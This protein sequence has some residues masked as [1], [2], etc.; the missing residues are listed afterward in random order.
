MSEVISNNFEQAT[1]LIVDD[2][3]TNLEMVHSIVKEK[4]NYNILISNSSKNVVDSLDNFYCDL[5]LLDIIMPDIDGYELAKV[6]KKHAKFKNIPILFLTSLTEPHEIIKG[7]KVGGVDY[8]TKPFIEEELLARI[9]THLEL[10]FARD[11]LE[12]RELQLENLVEKKSRQIHNMTLSLVVALEN[13]NLYNDE[14]TGNH[15]KRVCE[16]SYFFAIKMNFP[17]AFCNKIKL[18]ASLHDVGKIGIPDKILKKRGKYSTEEYEVMKKHVKIGASIL[19]SAST[20]P[21]ARNIALY[22]HEK[23]DGSGYLHHLSGEDIPIEARIIALADSYDALGSER[24]YKE[25]FAES[26]IDKI[27][28]NGRGSHFDP[29]IVDIYIKYKQELFD[30]KERLKT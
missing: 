13:A 28:I 8:I 4:T 3:K 2:S 6:I 10:K 23:W 7:F 1:L 21:M 18:Y 24:T 12:R 29:A 14:D 11:S 9:K 27:I 16:Y 26:T 5:I 19:D 30:L 25:G 17:P 15:I 22:H 20:D